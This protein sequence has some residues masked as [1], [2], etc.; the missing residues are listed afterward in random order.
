M[1]FGPH[2]FDGRSGDGAWSGAGAAGA[3][4]GR[5]LDI[6]MALRFDDEFARADE[7]ADFGVAVVGEQRPDVAI[8]GLVVEMAAVAEIA[9]DDGGLDA[10]VGRGGVRR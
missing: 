7:A 3:F 9:A 4:R 5:A 10:L 1:D 2:F 6:G 8:D